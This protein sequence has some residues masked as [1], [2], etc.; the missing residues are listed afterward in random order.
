MWHYINVWSPLWL[1]LS[2]LHSAQLDLTC[3]ISNLLSWVS[4]FATY[5]AVLTEARPDLIKSRLAFLALIVV[6]ARKHGVMAGKLMTLCSE[7]MLLMSLQ[8]IG[9]ASTLHS[10][11]PYFY[12][13]DQTWDLSANCDPI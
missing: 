11:Q 3:E 8:V 12:L 6:E 1:L 4:C 2:W 9:P 10:M 13:N 7:R 5:T